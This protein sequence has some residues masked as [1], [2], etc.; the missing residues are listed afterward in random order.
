[1]RRALA[2]L[3]LTVVAMSAQ[4]VRQEAPNP[5]ATSGAIQRRV[6]P[7]AR[8][9]RF[10]VE[11]GTVQ[12][13]QPATLTWATENPSGVTLDPAMGT[14]AAR[15]SMQVSPAATT[16]YKLT[17][18]GPNNQVLTREATVTVPGTTPVTTTAAPTTKAVPRLANGRPDL[19][20]VYAASLGAP[21]GRGGRAAAADGPALKPGAE[22]YRVV[23]G[24]NDPGLTSD[25]M[26]LAGPQAFSV[27]YQFQLVEGAH[28]VAI[29]NE[30]PGTFRIIPTDG[31]PHPADPDPTWM[32]D[33]A[34]HWEGDTLVVDTVGFNDKTEI[35]G[36]KHS[37][38]LHIVERFSRSTYDTLQYEAT[39]D[40]ANVFAKPW[41]VTRTFALRPDM[42]KVDEFVCETNEDYGK[43]FKKE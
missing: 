10:T 25:C 39:L 3:V 4:T 15:G 26:P 1:M 36:F 16:T 28:Q 14:V 22:K 35:S 32:G 18:R 7:P 17:V 37:E 34:G 33:S 5:E 8:I 13:G 12:P 23:R 40:D 9:T 11:P 20:G 31:G 19:S 24:P 41:K 43:F 2:I 42:A 38:A 6:A 29:L 21:G 30:Y 27:P